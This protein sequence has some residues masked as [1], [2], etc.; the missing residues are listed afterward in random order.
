M[1]IISGGSI[2]RYSVSVS[3]GGRGCT[4][5]SHPLHSLEDD[6]DAD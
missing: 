1:F 3:V 5:A 2:L 6:E 4:P